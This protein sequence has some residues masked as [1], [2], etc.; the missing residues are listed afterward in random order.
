M[1]APFLIG[2]LI[3]GGF[4]IYNGINHFKQTQTLA[5]YAGAKKVPR[6]REAVTATGAMMLLGETSILLGVKPKYGAAAILG[7]LVGVSPIMHHFWRMEDPNQ[8][9]KDMV[10]FT[11]NLALMG[12]AA[13]MMAVDEPWPLSVPVG[14]PGRIERAT[15]VLSAGDRGISC[16]LDRR[17]R[18][19]SIDLGPFPS[20]VV[21]FPSVRARVD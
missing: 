2:Q 5:Q 16:R 7:F 20:R 19:S 11:K 3:F 21:K 17:G 12:G 9:L 10:N 4:F 18:T 13:A 8:R 15:K 1:K 14:Q 6:A